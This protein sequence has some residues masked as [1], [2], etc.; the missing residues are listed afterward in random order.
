MGAGLCK[1]AAE[2]EP[3]EQASSSSSPSGVTTWPPTTNERRLQPSSASSPSPRAVQPLPQAD[4]AQRQLLNR[5]R[6]RG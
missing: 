2:V 6:L 3:R 4:L 1:S 5:V